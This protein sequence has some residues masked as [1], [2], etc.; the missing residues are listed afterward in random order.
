MQCGTRSPGHVKSC[1]PGSHNQLNAM[2]AGAVTQ[3]SKMMEGGTCLPACVPAPCIP[4]RPY[5]ITHRALSFPAHRSRQRVGNGTKSMG[6]RIGTMEEKRLFVLNV[7]WLALLCFS[8]DISRLRNSSLRDL[9][10][11][12]LL[13]IQEMGG[14]FD[15][16]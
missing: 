4:E 13:V 9:I 7:A 3:M 11:V 2:Q 16:P 12:A 1:R 6:E 5:A 10:L 8:G 15:Y 14:M